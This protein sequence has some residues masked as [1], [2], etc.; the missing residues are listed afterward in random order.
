MFGTPTIEDSSP[1]EILCHIQPLTA[2]EIKERAAGR[3]THR[4]WTK[5]TGI[6][7]FDELVLATGQSWE[8]AGPPLEW[9]NPRTG[10]T[11]FELHLAGFEESS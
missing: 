4:A 10:E 6:R 5:A 2:E 3:V 9:E 8:I 1:T 7:S 11:Y